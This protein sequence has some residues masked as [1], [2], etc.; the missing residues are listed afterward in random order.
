MK[1][2]FGLEALLS[3]FVFSLSSVFMKLASLQT[4]NTKMIIFFSSSIFCLMI[5]SYFW[6][7]ILKKM[8]LSKAYF[9]KTTTLFWGCVL[10]YI[11]F[12]EK[13]TM[14]MIVALAI[15]AI[16]M[17]VVLGDQKNE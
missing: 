12:N 5:F 15:N 2:K 7:N 1:I 14:K 13:I 6:Q 3:Y 4:F 17:L 10:G 16:G 9:F 11:V 8:N